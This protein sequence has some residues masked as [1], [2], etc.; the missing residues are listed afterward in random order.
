M[1]MNCP[2]CN[3]QIPDDAAFCN[4][5]GK[6][7]AVEPQAQQVPPPV[8]PAQQTE[9]QVPPPAA[10]AAE[11]KN[12]WI[13]LILSCLIPGLGQIYNGQTLKGVVL[14]LVSFISA[15]TLAPVAWVIAMIDAP[16]IAKKINEGK[17]VGEWEFF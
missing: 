7:T 4:V 12:Q 13:A 17:T 3:N 5:C 8:Q 14:I 15:G 2:H 6:S 9:Q 1:K 10:P 11:I 16:M